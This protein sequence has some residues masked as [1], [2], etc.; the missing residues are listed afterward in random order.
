MRIINENVP[1]I[2][3][4]I[5][6]KWN[7]SLPT[8][9]KKIAQ[10]I[11]DEYNK[12]ELN[13]IFP[14]IY[15][16]F[17]Y[18]GINPKKNPYIEFID[19]LKFKPQKSDLSNF[20][21]LNDMLIA[22]NVNLKNEYLTEK[23]L[24]ERSEKDFKYTVNIFETI[25]NR[26]ELSKYFDNITDISIYPLYDDNDNILPAGL[27]K[28][29]GNTIYNV[30]E[31]WDKQYNEPEE[32]TKV[33]SLNYSLQ[34]ALNEFKVP[35]KLYAEVC[36]RWVYRYFRGI[37]EYVT[38]DYN[39]SSYYQDRVYDIL[40]GGKI[41]FSKSDRD[42]YRNEWRFRTLNNIPSTYETEGKI[43]YVE[44]PEDS[45]IEIAMNVPEDEKYYIYH[46]KDWQKVVDYMESISY[47]QRDTLLN[48]KSISIINDKASVTA[49]I[50]RMID[51]ID[52]EEIATYDA[53]RYEF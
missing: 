21:E 40:S 7:K 20:A 28:E 37:E 24:Y 50:I 8:E 18:F 13:N 27:N 16:N 33:D 23:S 25:L 9:K 42:R 30:I 11:V 19:K 39:D 47:K 10:N 4:E 22:G 1:T 34:E 43:V 48:T 44:N 36:K 31:E 12:P 29:K 5:I 3:D 6:Q 38:P 35:S 53:S 26:S 15:A 52:S 17:D 46:N 49:G 32:E 45:D 41:K 2:S 14:A 51:K